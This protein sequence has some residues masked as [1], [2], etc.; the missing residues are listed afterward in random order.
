MI[1]RQQKYILKNIEKIRQYKKEWHKKNYKS[2][3]QR[4]K[5]LFKTNPE[6]KK[7]Y[8]ARQKANYHYK[9]LRPD[10]CDDC[11]ETCEK[12]EMH[13]V[14]YDRPLLVFW[15]CKICHRY[16]DELIKEGDVWI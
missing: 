11:Q 16:H 8:Y 12:I 4:R 7:K 10:V 3:Y 13:H 2:I 15:L 9:N 5:E 14:D 1:T 6:M